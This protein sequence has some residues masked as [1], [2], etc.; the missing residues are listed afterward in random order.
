M[1]KYAF[2]ITCG[3]IIGA[4]VVEN[5]HYFSHRVPVPVAVLADGGVYEGELSRGQLHGQGKLVWPD[6]SYYEGQFADGVFQGKGLLHTPAYVY[7]GEFDLGQPSGEGTIT[8]V[9]GNKYHGDVKLGLPN[10]YGVLETKSTVYKGEFKNSR[11]H[12]QGELAMHNGDSYVG[13]FEQGLFHGKGVFSRVIVSAEQRKAD[14]STNENTL[15]QEPV[16]SVYSG[17]FVK[18]EFT[19]EGTWLELDQRYEGQFLN[20]AFHGEG[21]YSDPEGTYTGSFVKGRYQGEGSYVGSQGVKYQGSF[22]NGRY[23]G[24]GILTTEDGDVYTGEFQF[25]SKHG[26]GK[27]VYAQTLDG[28]AQVNGEWEYDRLVISDHP[29]LVIQEG[30]L[31]EHAL[32]HQR[33]LLDKTLSEVQEQDPEQIE[34]YFVGVAGDGSQG[35][36]RR[37][38]DF[39]NQML[40]QSYET[41]NKSVTLVNSP[42]THQELPLATVTSIEQTLQSVAAK[43]DPEN[44]ILFLYLTSH[45]TQDFRFYLSQPGLELSWLTAEALGKM[46]KGLPVKHKVVVVSACFSGGFVKPLKDDAT[47]VITAAQA[48]KASFGCSDRST[49]T[50][51]GEAFFKDALHQSDSFVD[52]FYRA[53]DIVKGREAKDGFENSNPLIYKPKAIVAHLKKWR[54]QLAQ[55]EAERKKVQQ[56]TTVNQPIKQ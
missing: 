48:D 45:G 50:Y 43:M 24:K 37:E 41:E 21:M 27:L 55:R 15:E 22:L 13:H 17:D 39:V 53:R 54:E 6:G 44:D 32:Y 31:V 23:H 49:M 10:G 51:F 2:I 25:G 8:Y 56:Q 3:F 12:G 35:V 28:I 9:S 16:K 5:K 30:Q 33:G 46:V 19:G 14:A 34:L 36:F 18:G 40:A 20:W 11:Y 7:E 38:M 47:M 26:K 29:Q 42:L 52:A 4:L 1:V